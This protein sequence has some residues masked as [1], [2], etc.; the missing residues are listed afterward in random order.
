[1]DMEN[2]LSPEMLAN[3]HIFKSSTGILFGTSKVLVV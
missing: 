3:T 1:M 2:V